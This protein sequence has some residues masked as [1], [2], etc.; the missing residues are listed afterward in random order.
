MIFLVS[1]KYLFYQINFSSRE[2]ITIVPYVIK[3]NNDNT[4]FRD[5]CPL[6]TFVN[7][8]KQVT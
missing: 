5:K 7:M 4:C 1:N 6:T 8:T 2:G 3:V